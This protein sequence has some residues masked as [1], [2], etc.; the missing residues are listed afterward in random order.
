MACN[1]KKR[2]LWLS[3]SLLCTEASDLTFHGHTVVITLAIEQEQNELNLMS[4]W[5]F[6]KCSTSNSKYHRDSINKSFSVSDGWT[7]K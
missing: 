5:V 7:S 2:T 3:L 4:S 1:L 6:E